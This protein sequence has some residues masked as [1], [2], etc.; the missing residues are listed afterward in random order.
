MLKGG[1]FFK[2]VTFKMIAYAVLSNLSIL[3]MYAKIHSIASPPPQKSEIIFKHRI[4]N[5]NNI[6]CEV[7]R[8]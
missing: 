1:T 7:N 8:L 4:R 6:S 3:L 5:L 2:A